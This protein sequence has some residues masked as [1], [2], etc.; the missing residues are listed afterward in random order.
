MAAAARARRRSRP[1]TI[2]MRTA[3]L[4]SSFG[5]FLLIGSGCDAVVQG[6]LSEAQ[7]NQVLVV[8]DLASISGRKLPD[9]ATSEPRYRIEVPSAELTAALRVLQQQQLPAPDVPSADEL[10]KTSGL[11]ATP[12]EERARLSAVTANELS[13]SLERF[14]G[15]MAARVHLV[16][17]SAFHPLDAPTTPPQAAVLLVR[18]H[19]AQAIDE[20]AVR[21]LICAAVR[22]LTESAVSIVQTRAAAPTAAG[23]TARVGPFSVRRESAPLLRSVLT[24]A[25]L[26]DIALAL[27]LIWTVRRKRAAVGK[28]LARLS[29]A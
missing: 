25:L 16:L 10:L 7:A 8:L 9:D 13:R 17:P 11:I 27:A 29:D 18:A 28:Q 24:L 22:G 12:D 26:L 5:A 6:G 14:E 20:R 1:G 2:R 4:A 15:V 3:R 23:A 21:S 19:E